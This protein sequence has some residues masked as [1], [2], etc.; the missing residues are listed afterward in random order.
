M[1]Q[2]PLTENHKYKHQWDPN[3]NTCYCCL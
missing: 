2:T 1:Q 3:T